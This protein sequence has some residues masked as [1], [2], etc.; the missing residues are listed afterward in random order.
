M[1]R[2]IY[3]LTFGSALFLVA[4]EKVIDIPLIEADRKIV[5]E[6]EMKNGA[7]NN[8][9]LLSKTGSVYDTADFEHIS[10]ASV[11]VTDEAGTEYI[12][13]EDAA[14]PGR[15]SNSTLSAMPNTTYSMEIIADGET[16][17]A[18]SSTTSFPV[19]DNVFQQKLYNLFGQFT[20]S[21]EDSIIIVVYEFLDPASEVN[22][23]LRRAWFN[24]EPDFSYSVFDDKLWNGQPVQ[25]GMWEFDVHPGDTLH[26]ELMSIDFENYRFFLTLDENSTSATSP[27]NPESNLSGNAIG[28]FG[29]YLIDS[30]SYI[31]TE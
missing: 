16:I 5:V 6:M 24:S 3:I 4:C 26:V 14:I 21:E 7:G 27:A 31:V 13:V 29:A 9:C 1:K 15:Y 18:Q 28:Y 12:F 17:T 25:G 30:T 19:I 11:K 23:Y 22:Y 8:Y 10:G 20:G 2:L